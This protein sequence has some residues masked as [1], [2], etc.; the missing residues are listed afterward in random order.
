MVLIQPD[1]FGKGTALLSLPIQIRGMFRKIGRVCIL[2]YRFDVHIFQC[3]KWKRTKMRNKNVSTARYFNKV[4]GCHRYYSPKYSIL[5]TIFTG[6]NNTENLTAFCSFLVHWCK[7]LQ[8]ILL[9][10]CGLIFIAENYS[11]LVQFWIRTKH[12]SFLI[13]ASLF[14]IRDKCS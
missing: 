8:I 14:I 10:F 9:N 7:K 13:T 4:K 6:G 1:L 12:F 3:E 11:I 2:K 5:K